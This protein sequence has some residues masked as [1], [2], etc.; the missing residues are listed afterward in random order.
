ML[1]LTAASP[2]RPLTAAEVE[3]HPEFPHVTWRLEPAQKGKVPVAAG[4]GGP[5][6]IA[7][8][9]HGHGPVHIVVSAY[10]CAAMAISLFLSSYT[11]SMRLVLAKYFMF[12]I[13][14]SASMKPAP[15]LSSLDLLANPVQLR[16]RDMRPQKE[17]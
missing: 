2:P 16:F 17:A 9:V 5:L 10:A 6:D 14:P 15:A 13:R 11:P 7:Y 8:E 3:A 4:R 1:R 12:G